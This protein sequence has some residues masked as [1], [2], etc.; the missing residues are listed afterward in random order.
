MSTPVTIQNHELALEDISSISRLVSTV[1]LNLKGQAKPLVVTF[2]SV[3]RAKAEYN[4]IED[5]LFPL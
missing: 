3:A 5:L 2:D 1:N 4:R